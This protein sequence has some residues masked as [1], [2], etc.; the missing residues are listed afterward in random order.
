METYP[1]LAPEGAKVPIDVTALEAE[2]DA[3][4]VIEDL[5]RLRSEDPS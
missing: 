2:D 4:S 1:H 5:E 3:Y